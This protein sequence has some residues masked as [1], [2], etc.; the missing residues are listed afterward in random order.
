MTL[1]YAHMYTYTQGFFYYY[2]FYLYLEVYYLINFVGNKI[3]AD[4]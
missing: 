2:I 1:M 3:A 4:F